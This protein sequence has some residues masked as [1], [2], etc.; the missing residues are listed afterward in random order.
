MLA[1]YLPG[2]A[3]LTLPLR[4]SFNQGLASQNA[5]SVRA[6]A[7]SEAFLASAAFLLDSAS[8]CR[9]CKECYGNSVLSEKVLN[10]LL[11]SSQQIWASAQVQ[12]IQRLTMDRKHDLQMVRCNGRIP[13]DLRMSERREASLAAFA[14]WSAL[15][16]LCHLPPI[17]CMHAVYTWQQRHKQMHL[18]SAGPA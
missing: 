7:S 3:Q 18:R 8:S 2:S 10:A 6:A 4:S 1:A 5:C 13:G 15:P 9:S 11:N 16:L 17:G 12:L 14:L